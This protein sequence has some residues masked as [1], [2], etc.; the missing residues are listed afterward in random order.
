VTDRNREDIPRLGVRRVLLG[1][2]LAVFVGAVLVVGIGRLAGFTELRETLAEGN[3]AWLAVCAAAQLL[4]FGGYAG[5]YVNAVRFEHG[6]SISIRLALRVVLASFGLTQVV[7]AAG[8]AGLAVNYWALRRLRFGRR[9][10]AVRM[11][12]FNT[13]VYLVFGLV[14]WTSALLALVA[15]V[16]PP[17]MTITWLAAVPALVAAAAWFTS[18]SRV[19]RWTAP[20]GNWL[21]QGLALGIGA[22]WW[23][24]RSLSAPE[25]P[26]LLLAAACYWLG[27]TLSLWAALHAFGSDASLPAV[28][29]A[30]TTGYA[31]QIIPVPLIAT[32]GIDAATTFALQ[33][34]GVPLDVALVAVV[35]N[36]VFAFWLPL[37]PG[38][39]F[40][41]LLPRTGRRLEQA[42]LTA[43]PVGDAATVT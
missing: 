1:I 15:G 35:A 31:A 11:I 9:E 12:G 25:G 18:P 40:T 26:R 16:A 17:A 20:G 19:E 36:R 37:W 30:F 32:G 21:R 3:H 41:A 4:V 24:R 6:P 43:G 14:G 42:A 39:V 38:L 34:V 23:V 5:V 13:L 29:V 7:A 28:L 10:A 27:G 2:G 8:A 33:A 22:A